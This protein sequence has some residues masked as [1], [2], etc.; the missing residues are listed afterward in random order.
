MSIFDRY[1]LRGLIGNYVI[2]LTVMMSLYMVLD[3]FVNIDEFTES[4]EPLAQLSANIVSYYASH[5][6]LYFK[7]LSGVITLFAC[8][9]TIARMRRSNELTAVLAAGVSLYRVAVPVLGFGIATSIFWYVDTEVLIPRVAHRLARSHDD[10]T[11]AQ[12]RGVWFAN[13]GPNDLLSSLSFI[14]ADQRLDDLLVFH[15]DGAGTITSVTEAESAT[16]E[17][18]PGHPKGGVWQ[19]TNGF[20][21]TRLT[22]RN[23]L[24]PSGDLSAKSV[25]VLE[26]NLPPERLEARQIEGWLVY[27]SSKQLADL[28][29]SEPVL[30]DRIR[31]TKHARFTTPLVHMLLLVLGLPFFLSR[32]PANVITDAGRS[33][34]VCGT[35]YLL[36]YAAEHFVRTSHFSALPAWLPLIIFTPVAVVLMDRVRT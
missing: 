17:R 22:S 18:I 9:T 36:A 26:S 4:G 23:T 34:A 16:W 8:L 14:P 7:Q 35:C 10:A 13:D 3:L 21:T 12:S 28:R 1:I 2:A 19:L 27:S 5:S 25:D 32:E 20:E 29:K 24:M 11:G 15:R 30:A 31:R 33:L 6:F